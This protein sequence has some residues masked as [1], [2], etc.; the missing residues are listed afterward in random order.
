MTEGEEKVSIP[1]YNLLKRVEEQLW[2]EASEDA[3]Q[4]D[5]EEQLEQMTVKRLLEMLGYM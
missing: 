2:A 1:T 3:T 4:E 5:I